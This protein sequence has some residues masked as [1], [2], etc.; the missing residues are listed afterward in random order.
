VSRKL[1]TF[2]KSF[3]PR[4][5]LRTQITRYSTIGMTHASSRSLVRHVEYAEATAA[6]I[7]AAVAEL[8]E[9]ARDAARR[10]L[11]HDRPV[12]DAIAKELIAKETVTA[13]RLAKILDAAA[14]AAPSAAPTPRPAGR[15]DA[16][17][18]PSAAPV[19]S[20]GTA[21]RVAGSE[22]GP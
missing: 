8:L 22:V 19:S 1:Q 4:K 21:M 10:V 11:T 7:D 13:G 12:L 2:S 5:S 6:R 20:D 14:H 18:T 15:V 3:V 16:A 17:G 9:G